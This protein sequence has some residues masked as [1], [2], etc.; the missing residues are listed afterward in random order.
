MDDHASSTSSGTDIPTPTW[1]TLSPQPTPPLAPPPASPLMH[2]PQ[3][4]IATMARASCMHHGARNGGTDCGICQHLEHNDAVGHGWLARLCTCHEH[5]PSPS[6][7]TPAGRQRLAS[8]AQPQQGAG[9]AP[10]LD[11]VALEAV[12]VNFSWWS[13]SLQ[14]AFERV[15][16]AR[17]A[18]RRPAAADVDHVGMAGE[19]LADW[20]P[21]MDNYA[22]DVFLGPARGGSVGSVPVFRGDD[23]LDEHYLND[24][25]GLLERVSSTLQSQIDAAKD[26]RQSQIIAED[27]LRRRAGWPFC[28]PV[29]PG[30]GGA[31]LP[32]L[33]SSPSIPP[34]VAGRGG[35]SL[36]PLPSSPSNPPVVLGRGGALLPPPPEGLSNAPTSPKPFP[37]L[38]IVHPPVR[39]AVR[40]VRRQ[41][42]RPARQ[43]QQPQ[44]E[45]HVSS[46]AAEQ[47]SPPSS[48]SPWS[49]L[50]PR[51][52]WEHEWL[53]MRDR[54]PQQ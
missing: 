54:R 25:P 29:A 28:A 16:L 1:D 43:Q 24:G 14:G 17:M 46:T 51:P 33:P 10:R 50:P 26:E 45:Q 13:R 9:G 11:V 35:A 42:P 5:N 19:A 32:P 37:T 12:R 48:S 18:G 23:G 27:D 15:L 53:A 21:H 31:L 4:P 8:A 2:A 41:Q 47:G 22:G 30:R 39:R 34:V 49:Y 6:P 40:G 36:P 20:T 7:D 52:A 3:C 38:D 44:P